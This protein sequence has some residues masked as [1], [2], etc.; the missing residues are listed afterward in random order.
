MALAGSGGAAQLA[1]AASCLAGARSPLYVPSRESISVRLAPAVIP[2]AMIQGVPGT[3]T[4]SSAFFGPHTNS[5]PLTGPQLCAEAG[6]T[7]QQENP[8][9]TVSRIARVIV[10]RPLADIRRTLARIAIGG[11]RK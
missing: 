10:L 5:S 4:R 1:N 9:R 3:R 11:G 6:A 8:T 2:L 7:S